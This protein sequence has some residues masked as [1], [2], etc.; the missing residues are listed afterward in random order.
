MKTNSLLILSTALLLSG[1]SLQASDTP[2]G[3]VPVVILNPAPI[4]GGADDDQNTTHPQLV[5]LCGGMDDDQLRPPPPPTAPHSAATKLDQLDEAS[6]I[7][8]LIG[9]LHGD[10]DS[11]TVISHGDGTDILHQDFAMWAAITGPVIP[12]VDKGIV[13]DSLGICGGNGND[14]ITG[15]GGADGL[16]RL[17]QA[18]S[19]IDGEGGPESINGDEGADTLYGGSGADTLLRKLAHF[20]GHN[21]GDNVFC[22]PIAEDELRNDTFRPS[23]RMARLQQVAFSLGVRSDITHLSGII[24]S[25]FTGDSMDDDDLWGGGGTDEIVGG[26]G[27]DF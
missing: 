26:D 2:N 19:L 21:S 6:I 27:A 20:V 24:L 13:S 12:P 17:R 1:T 25:T 4:C 22:G 9:L 14:S 23:N 15:N 3:T 18:V 7:A 11:D 8:I 5:P 16:N 10:D